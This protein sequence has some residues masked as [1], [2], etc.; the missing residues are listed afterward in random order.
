MNGIRPGIRIV[1]LAIGF[2]LLAGCGGSDTQRVQGTVTFKGQPLPAGK[3]YFYPDGSQ[4]NTGT[5]GFAEIVNG[6]FDTA[7]DGGNGTVS[8]AARVTIEGYDPTPPTPRKGE[9]IEPGTM[10]ILFPRWETTI[11]IGEK[12]EITIDVP[13]EA[14]TPKAPARRGSGAV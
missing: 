10:T 6:K 14:A 11:T 7:A 9:R 5:A 1:C 13:A 2:P 3:I 8:G 4:G 12:P